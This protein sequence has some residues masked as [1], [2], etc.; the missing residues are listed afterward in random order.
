MANLSVAMI[1]KNEEKHLAKCLESI[2]PVAEEIV[3]VD[4]GS[5]DKTV[6]V[7]K[8]YTDKVYHH[9]WEDG[10]FSGA[11]NYGLKFVTKRWV[12]WI[13]AD[14]W[15]YP[16]GY[17]EVEQV[18]NRGDIYA[19]FCGLL[20]DLPD[21]RLSKH[22]LPKFFRRGSAH[23]KGIVHNQLVH[24]D[25]TFVS[26]INFHHVGY[27]LAPDIL[28]AKRKRTTGL[29]KKQIKKNKKDGFAYMNISRTMMNDGKHKEA[30]EMAEKGLAVKASG[31]GKEMLYY[32]IAMCAGFLKDYERAEEACWDALSLNPQNLD[33]TFLLGT[34]AIAQKQWGKGIF[35]LNRYLQLKE[36]ED[37]QNNLNFLIV[38]F[39]EARDRAY[40]IIGACYKNL[41]KKEKALEYLR[42]SV[43]MSPHNPMFLRNLALC[44]EDNG[45][46]SHAKHIWYEMAQKGFVD[47]MV[48]ERLNK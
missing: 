10:Y 29:L 28:A 13:D 34:N 41:D 42:K 23:F 30:L 22:F 43:K 44:Y 7:A 3:I 18:C 6:E 8:K 12:L 20:S 4:T 38:D 2:K 11:R 40:Q 35:Y 48:L 1:V 36:S 32:S 15:I 47:N 46:M 5:T 16:E 24:A 9:D 19:I 21:G 33:M 27:A 25:P 37:S 31:P 45:H 14:E 17:K 26:K 39:W